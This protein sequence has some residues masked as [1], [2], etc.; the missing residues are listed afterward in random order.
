MKLACI[1]LFA[2]FMDRVKWLF[3]VMMQRRILLVTRT[4]Y[5]TSQ[6]TRVF[7]YEL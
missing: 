3:Y 2:G 4:L 7:K 6:P 5:L 1:V